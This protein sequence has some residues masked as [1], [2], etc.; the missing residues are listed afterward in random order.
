MGYTCLFKTILYVDDFFL[1]IWMQDAT[2]VNETLVN[3]SAYEKNDFDSLTK[4]LFLFFLATNNLKTQIQLNHDQQN[5]A[6]C[7]LISANSHLE[8]KGLSEGL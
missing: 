8:V 1:F 7:R 2:L 6:A 3:K 5:V 4:H